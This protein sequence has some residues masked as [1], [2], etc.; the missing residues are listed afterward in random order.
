LDAFFSSLR[1]RLTTWMR[2]LV[3]GLDLHLLLGCLDRDR[4]IAKAETGDAHPAIDGPLAGIAIAERRPAQQAQH[5]NRLGID[6]DRFGGW[7]RQECRIQRRQ[8][9]PEATRDLADQRGRQD[10]R[11]QQLVCRARGDA[12]RP[13]FPSLL[14]A[15]NVLRLEQA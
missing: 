8:P 3:E 15:A 2:P 10:R 6:L 9:L 11:A 14:R 7:C 4:A 1:L 5:R 12:A 13:A